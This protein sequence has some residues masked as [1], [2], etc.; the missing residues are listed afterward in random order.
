M[1]AVEALKGAVGM[2]VRIRVGG[3]GGVV[4][5]KESLVEEHSSTLLGDDESILCLMEEL[6]LEFWRE[7]VERER[8]E[9]GLNVDF[10]VLSLMSLV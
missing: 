10:M 4:L 5:V 3:R 9:G 1:A 7:K 8:D 2:S 6:S